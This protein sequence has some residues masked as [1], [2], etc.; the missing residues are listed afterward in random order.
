MKIISN[1]VSVVALSAIIA[2]T[3]PSM[4]FAQEWI[5]T[6]PVCLLGGMTVPCGVYN[7]GIFLGHPYPSG[8]VSVNATC[9]YGS[10][11]FPMGVSASNS[12][13]RPHCTANVAAVFQGNSWQVLLTPDVAFNVTYSSAQG[14]PPS[15]DLL[16]W[17]QCGGTQVTFGADEFIGWQ[18]AIC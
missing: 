14:T 6:S 2:F 8:G 15:V 9:Q 10:C 5:M 13:D 18:Y 7:P 17:T 3:R 11:G 12:F 4:A 16:G 1:V